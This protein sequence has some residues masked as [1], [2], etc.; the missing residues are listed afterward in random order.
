MKKENTSN[1]KKM[2][3]IIVSIVVL[4]ICVLFLL[5]RNQSQS[6]VNS[7]DDVIKYLAKIYGEDEKFEVL[8]RNSKEINGGWDSG[9]SMD[10]Y[11]WSVK[12]TKND[13]IFSVR[14]F[15]YFDYDKKECV[16]TIQ[17]DYD[18]QVKDLIKNEYKLDAMNT[19]HVSDDIVVYLSNYANKEEAA[20]V[21]YEIASKY[22]VKSGNFD[23]DIYIS[24]NDKEVK[25][26]LY[27]INSTEDVI[28]K[29]M[30]DM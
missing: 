22:F 12:A 26:D 9:C 7:K 17:D 2:I 27:S 10:G 3:I 14:D 13:V 16:I 20:K 28:N 8:E 5:F 30:T 18:N 24:S 1:K 6:K 15:I 21:V 4:L 23:L 29:Y 11:V 25:V 19:G